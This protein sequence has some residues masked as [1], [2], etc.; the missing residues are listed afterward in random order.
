MIYKCVLWINTFPPKGGISASII[1]RTLLTGVK[2]NYNCHCKLAFGAYAQVHKQKFPTNSQQAQILGAICLGQSANLKGGYKFMN[3][4]TGK[5]LTHCRWTALPM[6][7]EVIDRVNKLG[8]ADGHPYLL[9]FYDRHG[10]LVGD[11]VNTNADLTEAPEE[12]TEENEPVPEITGVDQE[13]PDNKQIDP[14][15]PDDN[16]NDNDINYGTKETGD[17][18]E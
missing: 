17:P 7:Q 6:P 2:F 13:P 16:N 3:L 1:P 14:K 10:N 11:T 9:T 15:T 18:N 4:R 8:E 5:K 12:E